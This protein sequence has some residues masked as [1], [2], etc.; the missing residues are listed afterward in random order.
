MPKAMV[1]SLLA[2]SESVAATR[3]PDRVKQRAFLDEKTVALEGFSTMIPAIARDKSLYD[4]FFNMKNLYHQ[5][6]TGPGG[7]IGGRYPT[8]LDLCSRIKTE[9]ELNRAGLSA[10]TIAAQQAHRTEL[11][12]ARVAAEEQAATEAAATAKP[13]KSKGK[14]AKKSK[15]VVEDIDD[16]VSVFDD[17]E[18]PMTGSGEVNDPMQIDA[19]WVEEG[20]PS[21]SHR[22]MQSLD[23]HASISPPDYEGFFKKFAQLLNNGFDR[24]PPSYIKAM[25]ILSRTDPESASRPV[26]ADFPVPPPRKRNCTQSY[27]HEDSADQY[28]AAEL[29]T[30]GPAVQKTITEVHQILS[31]D[32][33][34]TDSIGALRLQESEI[35]SRIGFS[36]AQLRYL[37]EHREYLL[38]DL[39]RILDAQHQRTPAASSA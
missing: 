33:P 37:L 2:I 7:I 27:A 20:T 36:N 18:F 30:N 15:A 6:A 24:S 19:E 3:Y 23:A 17:S 39:S 10:A 4:V 5:T 29:A 16:D 1:D 38:K 14:K 32:Q 9:R 12:D 21:T 13:K 28:A 11:E 26:T 22:T 35:R 8:I 34:D 25:A 31:T